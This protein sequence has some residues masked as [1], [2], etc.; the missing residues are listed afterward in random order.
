M[1]TAWSIGN[2]QLHDAMSPSIEVCKTLNCMDD[3]MK[4]LIVRNYE[5]ELGWHTDRSDIDA[6]QCGGG[7]KECRTKKISIV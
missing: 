7:V 3:P 2:G 4:I 1:K 5:H 6:E